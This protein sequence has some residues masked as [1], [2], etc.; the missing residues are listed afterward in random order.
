VPQLGQKRALGASS[1]PQ[2][3]H[4]LPGIGD[5]L[6]PGFFPTLQSP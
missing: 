5:A 1:S 6:M 2:L 4:A 3:G